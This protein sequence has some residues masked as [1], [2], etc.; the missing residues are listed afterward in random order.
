MFLVWWGV[1]M[2][3]H[4]SSSRSSNNSVLCCDVNDTCCR[5][6]GGHVEPVTGYHFPVSFDLFVGWLL[7]G[8]RGTG[9]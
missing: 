5:T 4:A 9:M 1:W 2:G 6:A 8:H 7:A 3:R